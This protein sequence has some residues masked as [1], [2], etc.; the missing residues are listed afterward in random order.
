[1]DF[2]DMYEE[3][4]LIAES[5]ELDDR[6]KIDELLRI[7][8]MLYANMGLDSTPDERLDTKKKSRLIYRTIKSIDMEMGDLFLRAMR[9]ESD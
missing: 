4:D 6:Q 8:A 7:D 9:N 2:K 5:Q 3:I 1:M